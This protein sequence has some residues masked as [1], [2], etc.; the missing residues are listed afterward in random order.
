MGIVEAEAQEANPSATGHA[1]KAEIK[2]LL[3]CLR[4]IRDG[5]KVDEA[6]RFVPRK[7]ALEKEQTTTSEQDG[8]VGVVSSSGN[9]EKA[10]TEKNSSGS[11]SN[12]GGGSNTNSAGTSSNK[13]TPKRP[14]KK[15]PLPKPDCS[16]DD[17]HDELAKKKAKESP[18][19]ATDTEK[20]VVESLM[21]MNKSQ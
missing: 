20:S 7:K 1:P 21:L 18:V 4:P 8:V 5:E 19:N 14:P 11:T 10:S 13:S 15:R 6:F 17:Y 12:S 9:D 2:E 16:G 3:L